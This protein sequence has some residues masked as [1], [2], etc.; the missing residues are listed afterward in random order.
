LNQLP[1]SP[2]STHLTSIRI[3]GRINDE[4]TC[5]LKTAERCTLDEGD[6]LLIYPY[7]DQSNLYKIILQLRDLG[8]SLV[9][10]QT[11]YAGR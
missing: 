7:L 4:M 5:W 3:K 2:F 6:T 1:Y 10:V 8:L 11:G 9:S